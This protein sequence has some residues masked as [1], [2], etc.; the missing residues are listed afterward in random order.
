MITE[1]EILE[2]F[3][4]PGNIIKSDDIKRLIEENCISTNEKGYAC[5]VFPPVEHD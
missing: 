5:V 2:M 3:N 4:R 1:K